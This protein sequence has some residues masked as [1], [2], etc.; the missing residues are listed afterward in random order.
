MED[1]DVYH[2]YINSIEHLAKLFEVA[3]KVVASDLHPRYL[4]TQYAVS[5]PDVEVVKI[6]HHWAHIASVLAEHNLTGP[7]IG[8]SADGT[9]YGTDEAIWGCE[10]LIASL[11]DFERFGHLAYYS[12]P[13]A[14]KASKEAIRPIL[15]LLK[16][17]Y[18][19]DFKLRK[20]RWLLERIEPDANKQ[21][22]ILEQLEK[23]INTVETSSLGRVFDAVAAMLGLGSYNHF[24]AQL[25]MALEA[26]IAD[27]V[28]ERYD[29]ELIRSTGD[30]MQL[31]LS[32]MIKQ[33]IAD[34]QQ[35]TAAG[36][37]SAKFHNCLAE[38]M[39][40]M[41]K[42]A[43]ESK[44]LDTAALSG[45]VFCNRYLTN[46]CVKLLKKNDFRVLF[47]RDVPSNDGGIS[48]GQAAI[49][50]NLVKREA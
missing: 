50:A 20:F 15:G 36:V 10:C 41:A 38:S 28:E 3:P 19:K 7:V 14:D 43:R 16:K 1:A 40:E 32:K 22:I 17:T 47:N 31:D 27:G 8:L 6:Q 26:I 11:E 33:L 9:G 34:I 5:M 48:L 23:R 12:L 29:F 42:E 4:S 45:G 13:G 46:R 25:P 35:A 37:I 30:P 49:A 2:H 24:E 39:V 21:Q 44:K 18:G